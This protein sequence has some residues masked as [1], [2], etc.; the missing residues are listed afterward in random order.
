MD[1]KDIKISLKLK[2]IVVYRKK[3]ILYNIKK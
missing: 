3:Y 2:N 1:I